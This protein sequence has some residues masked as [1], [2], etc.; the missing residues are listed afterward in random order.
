MANSSLQSIDLINSEGK[1]VPG[2]VP[3]SKYKPSTLSIDE[4]IA[5]FEAE[6]FKDIRNL[7]IFGSVIV[8][9]SPNFAC[10][11]NKGITEPRDAITF[12][13][14]VPHNTVNVLNLELAIITFSIIAF[15]IPIAFIG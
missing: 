7:V 11:T 13:Y 3:L 12:P 2:L 8:R 1:P 15:E 14:R 9:T 10:L 6:S 5:V 4:Q